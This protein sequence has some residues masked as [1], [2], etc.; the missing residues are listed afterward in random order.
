[1][2]RQS[3][4]LATGGRVPEE[5]VVRDIAGSGE[6]F[7]VGSKGNGPNLAARGLERWQVAAGG[8]VP[9]LNVSFDIA[10]NHTLA[11]AGKDRSHAPRG[12]LANHAGLVLWAQVPK[13]HG[14][15]RAGGDERLTIG[16]K[17]DRANQSLVACQHL[18]FTRGRRTPDLD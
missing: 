13:P 4:P 7:F 2:T 8:N 9:L 6:R 17:N 1:M 11:A 16:R 15:I 14:V 12:V 18:R 10:R 5:D 3:R